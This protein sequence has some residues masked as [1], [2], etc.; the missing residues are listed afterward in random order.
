MD[1]TT[2]AGSAGRR[3]GVRLRT[4]SAAVMVSGG[5]FLTGCGAAD[6]PSSFDSTMPASDGPLPT[7]T[8]TSA[9]LETAQS[10]SKVPVYWLGHSNNDVFLYREF[11][12]VDGSGDPIQAALEAMTSQKPR[13]GDYFTPWKPAS[14][15]GASIS[16]KN[17]ITVDISSDA[18]STGLD[19]GI[20]RRA[21]QELV[22]TATAA[23]GNAGLIDANQPVQVAILVDGHTDYLAFGRVRLDKP[24]VR[25]GSFLAPVWVT[26][27]ADGTTE[28]DPVKVAGRAIASDGQL[29]W[30]LLRTD[31]AGAS[32]EYLSGSTAISTGPSQLGDFG[33]TLAP[34]AGRYELRVFAKDPA[35]AQ[36]QPGVDTKQLIVK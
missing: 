27:P 12:Q 14:K 25:E 32:T 9:P 5:L 35:D 26:E 10:A 28:A 19:D 23:A 8:V 11:V 18:F 4:L 31:S 17:V 13:D 36:A 7:S 22:Y 6:A 20:A 16:A 15:L 21:I 29:H 2:R 24:L 3:S 33:F 34:P 30:Q 1:T